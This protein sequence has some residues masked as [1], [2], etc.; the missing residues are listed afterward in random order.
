MMAED[1]PVYFAFLFRVYAD[2]R[3]IYSDSNGSVRVKGSAAVKR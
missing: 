1:L 3:F 2:K